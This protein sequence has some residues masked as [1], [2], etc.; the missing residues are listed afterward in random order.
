MIVDHK[1]ICKEV[2]N[3]NNIDINLLLSI[4]NI[5]FK[6]ISDWSKTPS[7]LK[8]YLKHFG[9]WYFKKQKT[10]LKKETYDRVLKN[11]KTL[12]DINRVKIEEKVKNY[13]FIISEYQKYLNDKYEIKYK[14]YGK[15]AYEAYCLDKKQK[16]IQETKKNK[17]I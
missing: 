15:E 14:K 2:S 3:E 16:K 4:N 13:E 12:L 5:I 6:E 11:D 7:T 17:S 1:S 9:N 10:I 8:I